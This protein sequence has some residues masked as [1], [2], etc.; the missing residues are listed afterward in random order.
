M[1]KHSPAGREPRFSGWSAHIR[2]AALLAA[3]LSAGI[4]HALPED[5]DQPIRITADT[6]I[7][8]EK[9]GFTVYT[10]NVHMIQ[11]SLDILADTIT[12][13]HETAQADKIVA[14]GKPAKMQQQPAVDEP[15]VKAEAEIIE[16]YK[17]EDRVHLKV[18]AHITQ[19]GASVAGDTIDYYITDQLVKADSEQSPDGKR[20]QVVIPPT[21]LREEKA[22]NGPA[23]SN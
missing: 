23:E 9:Q 16:Y 11:G 13:F 15:L 7:R 20:V 5:R 19:D 14:E 10:G 17:I 22:D 21:V 1:H 6:A 3:L 2:V 18:N 8:D 12:I 4:A